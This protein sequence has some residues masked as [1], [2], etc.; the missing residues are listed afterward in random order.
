ML[1]LG[2]PTCQPE[3][4]QCNKTDKLQC[5]SMNWR[6]DGDSDCDDESDEENCRK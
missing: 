6:C 2:K 5:I 1:I 4:F 3:E